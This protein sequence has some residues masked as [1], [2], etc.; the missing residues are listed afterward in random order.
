[1]YSSGYVLKHN[2]CAWHVFEASPLIPSKQRISNKLRSNIM[3][4]LF[5]LQFYNEQGMFNVFNSIVRDWDKTLEH[6]GVLTLSLKWNP[7][8]QSCFRPVA[9]ASTMNGFSG[10]SP[11]PALV[12]A[13]RSGQHPRQAL[14]T[15]PDECLQGWCTGMILVSPS[16]GRLF[17]HERISTLL[18]VGDWDGARGEES[19]RD[20]WPSIGQ[21]CKTC[22]FGTP[23]LEHLLVRVLFLVLLKEH[24][25]FPNFV[26]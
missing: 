13:S 1:M 23:S 15:E 9:S 22:G 26:F 11:M 14:G 18:N 21:G 3:S 24:L 4:V 17:F 25:D 6:R 7:C 8:N 12:A 16:P 10:S 20:I 2:T 5:F 19:E